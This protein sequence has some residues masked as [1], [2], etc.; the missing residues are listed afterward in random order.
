MGGRVDV[1]D[2]EAAVCFD[3]KQ[4]LAKKNDRVTLPFSAPALFADGSGILHVE[5]P[6]NVLSFT[7][8]EEGLARS[9]ES[10]DRVGETSDALADLLV[11][12]A[13]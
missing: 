11:E 7:R 3:V 4:Q 8:V 2:A 9:A 10:L 1:L 6:T 12:L 5:D 13:L